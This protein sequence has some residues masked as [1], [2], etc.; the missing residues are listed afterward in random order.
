MI[1]DAANRRAALI[2]AALSSFLT[3]FMGSSVNIA[4]PAIG[5]EFTTDAVTLSWV[6]TSAILAAAIFLVPFGR[7]GDIFGR[8]RIFTYGVFV[9]TGSALLASFSTS[10]MMLIAVRFTQGMG[11]AMIFST[12]TAILISVVPARD[13]GKVLGITVAAVYL[14]LT[15]GPTLGGFLT[16]QF[17]WRSVFLSNVPVGLVVLWLVTTK[18]EGE[19][20]E[21]QGERFDLAGSVLYSLSLV[22]MIFGFSG[23]P[24]LLSGWL[25]LAGALGLVAFVKWETS[26]KTPLIDI[27]LFRKKR[28]FAFSNL[29][30]LINYSATFA[31]FFLLSL[32]LQYIKGLSAQ[33]AGLVLMFQPIMMTLVAPIAGRLSDRIEPQILASAGMVLTF[34]GLLLLTPLDGDSSLSF[35]VT[36]LLVMGLGA[37]LFSSPNTNVVMSAVESKFYGVASATLSTMRLTGNMLSMGVVMLVFTLYIGRVPITPEYYPLFLRSMGVAF[38]IFAVL[39]FVGIFA[40]RIRDR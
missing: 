35:I 36:C 29:A 26:T 10:D 2:V 13:R 7:M 6:A 3:P 12:G 17:G 21:A 37:G 14:G 27:D 18:L 25:I 20:K 4:L 40:S 11:G 19:W 22:F 38:T 23:L 9:Y 34:L 31:V 39:S 5:R 33:Q 32:Y 24:D 1:D 15:L 8:K 16:Y 30:A 28:A